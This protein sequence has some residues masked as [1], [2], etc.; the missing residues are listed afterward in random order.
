MYFLSFTDPC[1][2]IFTEKKERELKLHQG[3]EEACKCTVQ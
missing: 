3:E 2:L 1:F